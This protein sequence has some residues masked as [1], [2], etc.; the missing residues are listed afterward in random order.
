MV[1]T[2]GLCK[3]NYG[4]SFAGDEVYRIMPRC[5]GCVKSLGVNPLTAT[6]LMDGC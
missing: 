4:V 1:L 2:E 5:Q 3:L 6:A